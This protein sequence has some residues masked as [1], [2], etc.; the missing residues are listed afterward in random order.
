MNKLKYIAVLLA[1]VVV[2]GLALTGCSS[3]PESTPST[4]VSTTDEDHDHEED[5]N[6][7]TE[8]AANVPRLAYTYDG[9]IR[10]LDALTGEEAG[11]IVL[12]GFNRLNPAGDERAAFVSTA[13]GFQV[14]DLGVYGIV[15]GDHLHYYKAEPELSDIVFR[16]T[17]PGHVVVHDGVVVLFDDATGLVRILDAAEVLDAAYVP[18]EYTTA[19]P[20]HGVALL[21]DGRLIVT[22][23]NSAAR[24]TVYVLDGESFAELASSDQCPDVH[25]EAVAQGEVSVFG[26]ADGALIVNG[27]TITKVISPD[28]NGRLSAL[29]GTEESPIVLGNYSIDGT[30]TSVA[31]LDT[32]TATMKLVEL[33]GGAAYSG[34]SLAR[35]D[36]AA[37][38]VLGTDG[39]LYVIDCETGV[40]TASYSVLHAWEAPTGWQEPRPSLLMLEGMA[41]ITDPQAR[42]LYIVYPATGEIWKTI[43]LSDVPNELVG[44][45]GA[46]GSE[47][48]DLDG[49]DH[50]D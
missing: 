18:T 36:D 20:H 35:G 24:S 16:A 17:T 34:H 33:P 25:G 41:Y 47:H 44:V 48:E 10:V 14:L 31:L 6:G 3:A 21:V 46:R 45:T 2:M 30:Y 5:A 12:A 38:L 8:S 39:K 50:D 28:V 27:T 40:I 49:H 42:Q 29:S 37:A 15:H 22:A 11:N 7:A 1:P 9:G 32:R 19:E 23:G 4:S 43:T 13:A 26:C